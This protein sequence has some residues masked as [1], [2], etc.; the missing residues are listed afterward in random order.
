MRTAPNAVDRVR[1]RRTRGRKAHRA[2]HA[3][4]AFAA[5]WL[6]AKGWR[7]LALNLK[8]Q[9]VEIDLLAR[10]G[11]VLAAVEVKTRPTLADALAAV[12][13]D[14]RARLRRAA[15]AL[16]QRPALQGL[17]VRLDLVALAP[18]RLPRHVPDAWPEDVG[19]PAGA[20]AR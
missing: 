17:S 18:R 15:E 2:G 16:T 13:P 12:L 4:E 10:R 14:Q 11:R 19:P 20:P 1:L 6:M 7:V 8:A 3:A 9:G 5:L